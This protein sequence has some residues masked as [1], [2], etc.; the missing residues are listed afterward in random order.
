CNVAFSSILFQNFTENLKQIAFLFQKLLHFRSK[1]IMLTDRQTDSPILP[2]FNSIR[3]LTKT[4]LHAKFQLDR[5]IFTAVIVPPDGQTDGRIESLHKSFHSWL[6]SAK[7]GV[8]NDDAID[9]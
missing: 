5:F 8:K 3:R 7:K 6:Q 2:I 4:D 9:Q 1:V